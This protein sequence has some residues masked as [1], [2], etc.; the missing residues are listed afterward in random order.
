MST[1]RDLTIPDP[2]ER[3]RLNNDFHQRGTGTG[4]YDDNGV[5]APWPH[6]IDQWHPVTGDPPSLEPGQQP[7]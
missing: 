3:G 2:D 6:D 4:F 7:F 5:P 1:M